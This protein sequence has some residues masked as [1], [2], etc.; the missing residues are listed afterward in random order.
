MLI[1][2]NFTSMFHSYVY[3][4]QAATARPRQAVIL[5][6]LK[7][8]PDSNPTALAWRPFMTRV[9]SAPPLSSSLTSSFIL[10]RWKRSVT[11]A[12]MDTSVC[13]QPAGV[14]LTVVSPVILSSVCLRSLT[15]R[16][17]TASATCSA[18]KASAPTTPPTAA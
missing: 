16:T 4:S 2:A 3:V 18:K 14:L 10:A 15:K 13:L 9:R 17:P 12:V 6:F 11:A 8:S 7:R 5:T 1:N